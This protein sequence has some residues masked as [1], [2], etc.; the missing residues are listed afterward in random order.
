MR[1]ILIPPDWTELIATSFD[2]PDA[3][4][5][6]EKSACWTVVEISGGQLW[7]VGGATIGVI[8]S[9]SDWP[10]VSD[11]F[12][13]TWWL[14][15][16]QIRASVP[17]IEVLRQTGRVDVGETNRIVYGGGGRFTSEGTRQPH[18]EWQAELELLR[19]TPWIELVSFEVNELASLHAQ[20][21]AAEA[22]KPG[23]L[24]LVGD[25]HGIR[26]VL[27]K[28]DDRLPVF[29]YRAQRAL[30]WRGR[31]Q[32]PRELLCAP[33][34]AAGR[35]WRLYRSGASLV[36]TVA[37]GDGLLWLL[38][39]LHPIEIQPDLLEVRH[40][41]VDLA[42][43]A[44]AHDVPQLP[45]SSSAA[46]LFA[47]LL[48]ALPDRTDGG[49]VL[50]SCRAE[51][52][53]QVACVVEGG[54]AH[55]VAQSQREPVTET[56]RLEASESVAAAHE[57][58]SFIEAR[59][60]HPLSPDDVVQLGWVWPDDPTRPSDLMHLG[61]PPRVTRESM[62]FLRDRAPVEAIKELY[63]GRCHV[64]SYRIERPD[65]SWYAEA[66]HLWPLEHGGPDVMDN[67]LVV[68]PTHHKELDLGVLLVDP[69]TGTL[70][71]QTGAAHPHHGQPLQF[72][73]GHTMDPSYLVRAERCMSDLGHRVHQ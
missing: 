8:V 62:R 13:D 45:R 34:I 33:P 27:G 64:C 17:S 38:P 41:M 5:Y 59:L 57:L 58:G 37:L 23:D 1:W 30:S 36:A 42:L 50:I 22:V 67:L 53:L 29:Q 26:L 6:T 31:F 52:T 69:R 56:R 9:I 43:P 70:R 15:W 55:L 25:G 65:G 71:A 16:R 2:N 46:A 60:G 3:Q 19:T 49:Q 10:D 47:D 7:I 4:A 51:L 35:S 14:P 39:I 44:E 66:H 18:P 28:P 12:S 32:L 72:L 68:C 54:R 21:A 63:Q 20:L 24:W 48:A 73:G 40:R 11:A 61:P